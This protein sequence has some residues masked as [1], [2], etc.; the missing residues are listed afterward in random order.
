[1]RIIFS[2][3]V[4]FCCTTFLFSK[5]EAQNLKRYVESEEVK[6]YKVDTP[7]EVRIAT[8]RFKKVNK[9]QGVVEFTQLDA[10]KLEKYFMGMKGVLSCES[11]ALDKQ[12]RI[13]S[14]LQLDGEEVFFPKQ[15]IDELMAMGYMVIGLKTSDEDVVFA[16]S[17]RCKNTAVVLS[18]G[19]Q[20]ID[21]GDCT[22]C[23]EQEISQDLLDKF[24]DTQYEGDLIDFG[25]PTM[26]STTASDQN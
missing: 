6:N 7:I 25:T 14:K 19:E 9:G 15:L 22:D 5:L 23:G 11:D 3:V 2:I 4:A 26:E 24:K 12:L 20:L 13:I 10:L 18:S 21:S 8:Y 1:M 17:Q 16:V